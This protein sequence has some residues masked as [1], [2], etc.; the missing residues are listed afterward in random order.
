M[1]KITTV[2]GARPQF[3]KA[4]V[5]SRQF[6]SMEGV[7]E[8]IVHTGQH[9]DDA[10]SKI[11]FDELDIPEP[12]VNLGIHSVDHCAMIGRLIESLGGVYSS[13]RPDMVL[14]YGD[15][16]STLAAAIAAKKNG[17]PLAHVEAGIRTGD[18]TAP[19]ESNRYLVD[20]MSSMNFCCTSVGFEN[21]V[22][23]G[24]GSGLIDSEIFNHGDV[25]KDAA[26]HFAKRRPRQLAGR[27]IGRP[28][29]VVT[30]HRPENTDS[31]QKFKAIVESL[32]RLCRDFDIVFPMH[33]RTV[34][35]AKRLDAVFDFPVLP[36]VG[37]IEMLGML[38]DCSGVLT[39]SGGLVREAYFFRRPSVLVLGKP[40]WVELIETGACERTDCTPEAIL[41][42]VTRMVGKEVSN[43]DCPFGDGNAGV[44]IARDILAYANRGRGPR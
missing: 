13:E 20:R 24:F 10:M 19:E 37:Y 11:F 28:S 25:M 23:E 26:L 32:N 33:P 1:V 7:S 39:D 43:D 27:R 21:L 15:T 22:K 4:A 3:V 12:A 2:V 6:K 29:I 41:S 30:M 14:V 38:A 8:S 5:L 16:N 36:P 42:A 40:A 44:S 34:E 17:I 18:E 9:F 35:A 31:P